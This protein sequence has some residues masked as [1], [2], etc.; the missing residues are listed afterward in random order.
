MNTLSANADN[1]WSTLCIKLKHSVVFIDNVSSEILHWNGGLT[2]LV[3]AGVND[4]REF[5]SF[6]RAL[7]SQ[8]KGVFIVS[9]LLQNVTAAVIQDIVQSSQFQY[10]IIITTVSPYTHALCKSSSQGADLPNSAGQQIFHQFED[11]VLEWLGNVNYTVDITHVP[12]S[13]ITV[14]ENLFINPAYTEMFPLS[15]A[16]VKEID[17]RIRAARPEKTTSCLPD[18]EISQ[19]PRN[20]QTLYKMFVSSFNDILEQLSVKE[21][22]YSI[23]HTSRCIAMELEN[24]GPA[25]SRRKN[26]AS[27][28]SVI[29]VDRSL[30][31][32]GA[33]GHQ[34][35]TLF[36]KILSILP[37][38]PGHIIDRNI[39]ME[40]MRP[41]SNVSEKPVSSDEPA[42][43]PGCLVSA[44][45]EHERDLINILI[46][47]NQKEAMSE[48]NTSILQA[49]VEEK[50]PV[51]VAV[52][53]NIV[54]SIKS[55]LNLFKGRYDVIQKHLAAIQVALAAIQTSNHPS[56][57]HFKHLQGMEKVILQ[58]TAEKN[59]S[60]LSEISEILRMCQSER[61][62]P[63]EGRLYSLD[64]IWCL[65]LYCY[66]LAGKDR[67]LWTKEEQG[68]Q[69]GIVKEILIELK[70]LPP[71]T[72][73][74]VKDNHTEGTVSVI[75]QGVWEK[76]KGLGDARE[77]LKQFSSILKAGDES[78]PPHY[79]SILRQIVELVFDP[80][81][82][83]LVDV[84]CKTGGLKDLLKTGFGLFM[85]ISKPRPN[86]HPLLIIYVI[87][88]I[89]TTE[90]KQIK[91][92]MASL[93]TDTKILFGSTQLV[94]PL[95]L[96]V[97]VLCENR[98]NPCI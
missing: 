16:D 40:S 37:S 77:D 93:K 64:D 1:L 57:S 59:V 10:V 70:N 50:L 98:M 56:N 15:K 33:V 18:L 28:A 97:S 81:K 14:G 54:D 60:P 75:V 35:E 26:C 76:L 13:T 38:L 78:S 94:N 36:D 87:G 86:D 72:K 45:D 69:A 30:D 7:P 21:D 66:S 29:F 73:A 58:T 8:K 51:K 22:I 27:K 80:N 49:A 84:E 42:I 55:I 23:G 25:K 24:Y 71:I 4:V 34:T 31:I 32:V 2:R 68:L 67:Y 12:L 20:L 92:M 79:K 3:K 83:E 95:S 48:I 62:K 39:N 11:N 5:S 44:Y 63:H 43:A 53:R 17:L 41:D 61:H 47:N 85:N 91:D 6:E 88:G 9:S 89:T 19:L 46:K 82:V 52:N 96:A 90:V 65:L 74:L